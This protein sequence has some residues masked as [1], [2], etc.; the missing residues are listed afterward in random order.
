M[1]NGDVFST[2]R[3]EAFCLGQRFGG[4]WHGGRD[5]Q[6]HIRECF[7]D[8]PTKEVC[9]MERLSGRGGAREALSRES[10]WLPERYIAKDAT[11]VSRTES[12]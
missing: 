12:R 9:L 3:V 4:F 6:L 11:G 8:L 7:C 5:Q 2:K 10:V 1:S